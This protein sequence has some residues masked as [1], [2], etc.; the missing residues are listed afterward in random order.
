MAER[1]YCLYETKGHVAYIT[2]N[3]PE[4]MNAINPATS[5]ELAGCFQ[6]FEADDDLWVAIYTG[7]GDR[8]FSAGMDLRASAEA[9][10]S[11]QRPQPGPLGGMAGLTNPR[12]YISKPIIAA[13][14]GYA[15]GGGFEMAM[16]CDIIIAS[17]TAQFGLPE[18]TRGIIAG[19]GGVHRLPRHM[20]LKI[21]M[22]YMLTGKRMTAQ[23]AHRWGLVNEVV[24]PDQLMPTAE[25]WAAEICENAP[26]AVRATKQAALKGLD[27]PLEAAINNNYYWTERMRASEDALEG[28]R[29][30]AEKRKPQWKGR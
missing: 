30:F 7:A 19:A 20:P 4:V 22:G 10:A 16:A 5:H 14:N 12:S 29:A 9:A 13:V 6:E 27:L 1:Q 8:A 28:P 24:P 3:R 25:R 26:I 21:A 2:I 11:G 15:L 23:E 18:V 17:E